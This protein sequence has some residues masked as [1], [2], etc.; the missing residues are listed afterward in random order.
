MGEIHTGGGLRFAGYTGGG[1]KRVRDGLTDT[2]DLGHFD[3][4]GRLFVDGRVDDM[5]VSGG[6][7]VF[8]G[9]VED[10]LG[11]HPGIA[12]TSV[13]GVDDER[14]SGGSRRT[15]C[16]PRGRAWTRTMSAPT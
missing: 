4:A 5:I 6:E 11:G 12:E 7:N 9:E 3:D 14:F 10:L 13:I 16:G 15:W 1:G 8:P 2:G